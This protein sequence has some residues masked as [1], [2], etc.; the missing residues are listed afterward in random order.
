[1]KYLDVID[2]IEKTCLAFPN[3]RQFKAG[4]VYEMN[5]HSDNSYVATV[6][7]LNNTTVEGDMQRLNLTLFY[8][9]RLMEDKANQNYIFSEGTH[10]MSHIINELRNGSDLMF[11][12]DYNFVITPFEERFNDL[13]SGVYV[14]FQVLIPIS[15][16]AC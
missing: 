8:I 15:I 11:D 5:E 1:M 2:I 14:T 10:V 3:V 4:N 7:T 12:E 6:L 13:C 16:C 9:D